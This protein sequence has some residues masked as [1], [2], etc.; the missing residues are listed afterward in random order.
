MYLNVGHR[1]ENALQ[2]TTARGA[3]CGPNDLHIDV[4]QDHY[5]A[6]DY[7]PNQEFVTMYR[8]LR[9]DENGCGN[10]DINNWRYEKSIAN[11]AS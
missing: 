3:I 2:F 5:D 11:F 7:C 6:H 8:A 9:F 4:G 10:T 1:C